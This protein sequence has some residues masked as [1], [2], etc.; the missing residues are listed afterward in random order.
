MTHR[1]SGSRFHRSI[2]MFTL[3]MLIAMPVRGNDILAGL[4]QTE[5]GDSGGYLHVR[6]GPCEDMADE[7]C[8]VIEAAFSESGELSTDYEHIGKKMLWGMKDRG[9]GKFAGGKIWAPDRDKTYRS[10]M[11]QQ[12]DE[13]TVKGCVGP[14]CRAQSWRRIQ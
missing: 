12:A 6:I 8:G 2:G 5:A 11:K 10:K 14:L 3:I 9:G 4:Y 13:L 7:F 1:K